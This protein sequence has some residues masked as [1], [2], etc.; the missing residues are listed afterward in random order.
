MSDNFCQIIPT[1]YNLY[2]TQT[3]AIYYKAIIKNINLEEIFEIQTII[4]R[5]VNHPAIEFIT[6]KMVGS[7]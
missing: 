2:N 6:Y 3:T 4:T 7:I 5:I 1:S